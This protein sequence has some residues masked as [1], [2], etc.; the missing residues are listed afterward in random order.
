MTKTTIRKTLWGGFTIALVVILV[1]G[2]SGYLA[3]THE[4]AALAEIIQ[5][6]SGRVANQSIVKAIADG[7]RNAYIILVLIF[8]GVMVV[9]LTG[10]WIQR[11]LS[12]SILDISRKLAE[13]VE[14]VTSAS[15]EIGT[16]SHSL[17]DSASSSAA[18]IEET[19]A[20][21]EEISAMTKQTADNA[22]RA[23]QMAEGAMDLMK[24][25]RVLMKELIQSMEDISKSSE[26]THK[27]IK[28]IDEISFQTNLLALNASVEAARAGEAGAGFAVVADE[29]RNL[30]MR[31]TEAAGNTSEMIE[32][33]TKKIQQGNEL[34]IQTD[35]SYRDVAITT[36][37]VVDFV[38][39]IA[40][41]SKEQA[42][43]IEHVKRA[44]A[45][46][47][48]VTQQNAASSE[49][50]ADASQDTRRQS[51]KMMQTVTELISLAGTGGDKKAPANP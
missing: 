30:A 16:T 19:S 3:V 38:I 42:Q 18:F 34:I 7:H 23:S 6:D 47:D 26:D 1:I 13:T 39:E 40:A 12:R 21:F 28:T 48:R 17:T 35:N 31:A 29:V 45:E 27:I 9:F 4:I 24:K 2:A 10:L 36:K 51:E 15:R 14:Q 44:V 25:A 11:S 5:G 8:S 37:K 41:A 20:S 32:G 46:I 33:I 43:R 22:D 50:F 49:Q